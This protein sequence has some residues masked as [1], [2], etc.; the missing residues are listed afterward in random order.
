MCSENRLELACAMFGTLLHGATLVPMNP[1]Y[2]VRELEHAF[3][4]TRPRLVFASADSYA[5]VH[6]VAGSC[7][8]AQ[9]VVVL[10]DVGPANSD[11]VKTIAWCDFVANSPGPEYHCRPQAMADKVALILF[12]SGTTG[13]PKGVELTEMNILMS[14]SQV[15]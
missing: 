2:T 8:F 11:T 6:S 10:D 3:A 13:L 15:V 5:A 4:L 14:I 1:T 12:S 7:A 9:T